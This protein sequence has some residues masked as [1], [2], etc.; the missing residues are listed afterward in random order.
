MPDPYFRITCSRNLSASKVAICHWPSAV[1]SSAQFSTGCSIL[2]MMRRSV[3]S[4]LN[5]ATV[6]IGIWCCSAKRTSLDP[7]IIAPSSST[8]SARTAKAG[9][10][11]R[12]ERT[13]PASVWPV[14]PASNSRCAMSGKMWPGRAKVSALELSSA[15]AWIVIVRS[16]ALTPVVIPALRSTETVN[17]VPR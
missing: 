2:L 12:S 14:L 8:I 17:A 13:T 10:F 15:S 16:A 6:I 7:R 5:S 3:A 4:A 9:A 1:G 11:T